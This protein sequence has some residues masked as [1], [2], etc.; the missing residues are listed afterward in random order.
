MT[1][2]SISEKLD[3]ITSQLQTL[4]KGQVSLK[5]SVSKLRLTVGVPTPPVVDGPFPPDTFCL[6]GTKF[7]PFTRLEW[8]LL[9]CLW[10]KD[11]VEL[12]E[13]LEHLY[14]HDHSQEEGA[15][16]SLV[17]RL[18][19]KL[20]KQ[21]FARRVVIRHGYAVFQGVRNGSEATSG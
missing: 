5:R 19:L 3:Y 1:L 12:A 15:L 4:K 14:G 13:V 10:G 9:A 2:D 8:R 20:R 16:R 21:S 6:N 7:G 17:K 18:N 11:A